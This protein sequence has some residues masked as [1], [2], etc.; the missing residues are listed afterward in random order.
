MPTTTEPRELSTREHAAL[1]KLEMIATR[2]Q[3][4]PLTADAGR[5]LSTAVIQVEHVMRAPGSD[6]SRK[7][8]H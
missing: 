8:E 1:G 5:E 4:N 2:L 6:A 7:D 3:R